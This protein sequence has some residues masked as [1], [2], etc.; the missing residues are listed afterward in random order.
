MLQDYLLKCY[1][2]GA[3]LACVQNFVLGIHTDALVNQAF[4][5]FSYF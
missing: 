4:I 3:A 2:K 1:L 5:S